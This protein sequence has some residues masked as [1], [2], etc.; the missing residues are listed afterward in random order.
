M[1]VG[2]IGATGPTGRA[3]VARFCEAGS[4]VVAVGRSAARLA[5]LDP[6]A[7]TREAD[8]DAVEDLAPVFADFDQAIV[9]A[10]DL[11]YE[12]ILAALPETCGVVVLLGSTRRFTRFPS[13]EAERMSRFEAEWRNGRRNGALLQCAMV[14]GPPRDRNISRL[15]AFIRG[16]VGWFPVIAPLPLGGRSLVQPIFREDCVEAVLAAFERCRDGPSVITVAGPEALPMREV[17]KACAGA[18]GR[19]VWIIGL[20]TG[21]LLG[22]ARLA[23]AARLAN[24][25]LPDQLRRLTEDKAF[26]IGEM[27]ARLGVDPRPFSEGLR[28]TLEACK[29]RAA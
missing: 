2:V 4:R 24:P 9:G 3:L 11:Y 8:L 13:H 15:I 14:F 10:P 22:V 5:E 7:E 28:L 6:R 12:R 25:R 21:L 19:R 29:S 20:P 17:V 16:W 26:D 27:R 23:V 1:T 18:L